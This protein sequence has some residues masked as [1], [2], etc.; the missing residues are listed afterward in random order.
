MAT[1]TATRAR[2]EQAID[3]ERFRDALDRTL[4]EV[5][6]DPRLAPMIC[7]GR[8][9]LRLEF[10]DLGLAL[11]L[12]A[13][14]GSLAWTFAARPAWTPRLVIEMDSRTANRYLQGTESLAIAIA[15]GRVRVRGDS[16]AALAH[17]PLAQMLSGPYRETVEAG[18]PELRT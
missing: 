16:R 10:T 1:A 2:G 5:R 14:A 8:P 13:E 15:R 12:G 11:N 4:A 6:A 17:L 18:F 9:R 3:A 7:A